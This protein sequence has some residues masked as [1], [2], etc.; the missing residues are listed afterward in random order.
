MKNKYPGIAQ[1]STKSGTRY[2]VRYRDNNGDQRAKNFRLLNE[3]KEFKAKVDGF[4]RSGGLPALQASKITFASYS[5]NW[6]KSRKHRPKTAARR[7]GILKKHLLPHLGHLTLDKIRFSTIQALVDRW[8]DD[9]YS[10]YTIRNHVNVL[11]S[12]FD[13]AVLDDILLKNPAK[14]LNLP[15]VDGRKPRALNPDECLALLNA[16]NDVYAPIIE[17]LIATGCRWGEL[18]SMTMADYDPKARTLRVAKSKTRAGVRTI[19]L[20]KEDSKVVLKHLLATGRV[21]APAH[22]PLFTSPNGLRLNYANFRTRVFLPACKAA[23][24]ENVR[25]HDLRRTHATMLIAAGHNAK[26]VQDRMGHES[27]QT[28]LTHYAVATA[29]DRAATANAKAIYLGSTTTES[30]KKDVG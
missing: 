29:A 30:D 4:R 3:A 12:I 28:T 19:Y 2:Q 17:T 6:V 13:L 9:G 25:I 14:G 15:K 18:E 24:I 7:D 11:S 26:A 21:G 5:A 8:T 23:G 27:I 16:A 1:N 10:P 20:D 22:E